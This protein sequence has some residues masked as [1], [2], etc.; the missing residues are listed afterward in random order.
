MSDTTRTTTATG[1]MSRGYRAPVLAVAG[2]LVAVIAYSLFAWGW[3]RSLEDLEAERATRC[4]GLAAI[5]Y[6]FCT[7]T[8]P[9]SLDDLGQ[10][11]FTQWSSDEDLIVPGVGAITVRLSLAK[12][13]VFDFPAENAVVQ[14]VDGCLVDQKT[15]AV[16]EMIRFPGAR[17]TA[18]LSEARAYIARAWFE[19]HASGDVSDPWLRKWLREK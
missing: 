16:Y 9:S 7:G 19:L 12:G 11:G 14:L 6:D 1:W 2:I 13:V 18:D 8:P 4:I 17:A 3:R 10:F 15:R 5:K